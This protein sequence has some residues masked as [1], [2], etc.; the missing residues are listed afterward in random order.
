MFGEC[1]KPAQILKFLVGDDGAEIRGTAHDGVHGAKPPKT[2]Y[3]CIC[4]SQFRLQ[5][6]TF[7]F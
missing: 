7:M 2:E 3:I 6:Y 4:D 5:F 1:R